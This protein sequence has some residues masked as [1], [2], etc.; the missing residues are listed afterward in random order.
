MTNHIRNGPNDCHGV[1]EISVFEG[2]TRQWVR[3]AQSNQS[4]VQSD[5]KD[6][7]HFGTLGAPSRVPGVLKLRI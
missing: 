7:Q 3:A 6:G 2:K 4:E 1:C 5:T